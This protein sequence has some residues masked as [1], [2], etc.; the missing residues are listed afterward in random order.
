M[1]P[2]VVKW[3]IVTPQLDACESF[4]KELFGW[5]SNRDNRLGYCQIPAGSDRGIDGGIW[6]GPPDAPSFVQLWIEVPEVDSSIAKAQSLGATII[7]P[8]SVL[9]DGDQMAVLRDP[10]G[11]TFGVCLLR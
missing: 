11:M 1:K 8:K 10:L 6:P 3:Q 5:T 9:P 2:A 7:V 4:Y